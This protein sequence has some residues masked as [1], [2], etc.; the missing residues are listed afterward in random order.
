MEEDKKD[1]NNE[2]DDDDEGDA[3]LKDDENYDG[4]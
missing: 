1:S 2:D 4:A 3:N